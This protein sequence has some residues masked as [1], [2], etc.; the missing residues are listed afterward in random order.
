MAP[1]ECISAAQVASH[2]CK[3]GV[4][5]TRLNRTP[6]RKRVSTVGFILNEVA[7]GDEQEGVNYARLP[8]G[9]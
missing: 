8:Q 4:E 6:R 2:R 3:E 9:S 7:D 5:T 1:L